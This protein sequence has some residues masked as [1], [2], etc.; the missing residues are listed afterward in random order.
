MTLKFKMVLATILGALLSVII[1][2]FIFNNI[3]HEL[4]V[5]YDDLLQQTTEMA[6][7]TFVKHV[8]S[9]L[10]KQQPSIVG[11]TNLTNAITNQDVAA[12]NNELTPLLHRL[13]DEDSVSD[14]FVLDKNK[15]LFREKWKHLMVK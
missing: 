10:V 3:K 8:E 11:N 9:T 15:K 13:R 1:M 7:D 2:I 14:I 12:V 6:H 4:T 5:S